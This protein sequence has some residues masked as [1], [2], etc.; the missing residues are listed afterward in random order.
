MKKRLL[1]LALGLLAGRSLAQDAAD[2]LGRKSLSIV[3]VAG[4]SFHTSFHGFAETAGPVVELSKFVSR[5]LELGLDVHPVIWISQPQGRNGEGR[6][7]VPALAVDVILRWYPGPLAARLLPYVEVAD[8]PFYSRRRTPTEG[9]R[10]NFLTQAGAGLVWRTGERWSTVV[11]YRWVH[12]S[13]ANLG[14]K[15][16]AWNFHGLLLGGRLFVP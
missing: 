7:N 8:G 2:G 11:G 13:N 9:T 10:L 4:Q 12:I 15:N 5:R 3:G 16:P 6:E 14:E 1:L